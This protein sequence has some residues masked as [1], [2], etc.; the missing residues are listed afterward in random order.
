MSKSILLGAAEPRGLSPRSYGLRTGSPTCERPSPLA[1]LPEGEGNKN[2]LCGG[3]RPGVDT[4]GYDMRPFSGQKH[5]PK[6]R[7]WGTGTILAVALASMSPC[8]CAHHTSA[9]GS[10]P[11]SASSIPKVKVVH[12][13][14]QTIVRLIQ[15][16]GYIRPYEQTP[17]Y[18]KIAGYVDEV[19]VDKGSRV[20]K[21][22]LLVRL[23]VPEMVQDVAAKKA[24]VDQ[25]EAEVTQAE[26]GLNAA[27]ANVNTA[28]A[29]VNE[30][31]AG[32]NQAEADYHRW[33]LE[34]E[35]GNPAEG[36]DLRS[37]DAD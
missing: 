19:P 22:D 5:D 11:E 34:C 15:Q 27:E 12:P 2:V 9:A 23:W 26:E 32:V 25:A 4:P 31:K 37:A 3:A 30:A 16:P 20:H 1:P 24:Q 7:L 13:T 14:R 33:A 36:E 17:V 28:E 18:S 21:G 8:G 29:N 35:R 6:R 10:A